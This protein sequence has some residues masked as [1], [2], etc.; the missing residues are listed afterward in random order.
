MR[1]KRRSAPSRRVTWS[2]L[3]TANDA[4]SGKAYRVEEYF[5][6]ERRANTFRFSDLKKPT[7]EL[8]T[9]KPGSPPDL[10]PGT[11]RVQVIT[12]TVTVFPDD[13]QALP[14][15]WSDLP[16]DPAHERFGLK[17]GFAERFAE[18]PAT[19]ALARSLP[20][21]IDLGGD[22][23]SGIDVLTVLDTVSA[24]HITAGLS[25]FTSTET[26][27]SID[28]QLDGGNDGERPTSAEYRG[29]ARLDSLTKTGLKALED[30]EDISIVAAPGST[31]QIPGDTR[32][33]ATS[34]P[35]STC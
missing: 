14:Q 34:R 12:L 1:R 5:D 33:D 9:T 4:S 18:R 23:T 10:I 2:G 8:R 6:E 13:P 31:Y 24:G 35:S 21:V 32:Y 30:I 11:H 26:A 25:D 20:I 22:I 3:Q 19:R 16:I 28:L 29:E 7:P 17:D 15:V 27:R